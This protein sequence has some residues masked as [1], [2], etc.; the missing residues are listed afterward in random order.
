MTGGGMI[1]LF[2]LPGWL[3]KVSHFSP[4]K[5]AILSIE[6]ALWRQFSFF[7]LVLPLSMLLAIGILTFSV[8]VLIFKHTINDN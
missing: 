1:P 7:E 8:G 4:V 3:I 5:W 6:G 2:I